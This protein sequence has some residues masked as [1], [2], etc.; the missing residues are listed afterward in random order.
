MKQSGVATAYLCRLTRKL[1]KSLRDFYLFFLN[2]A[3]NNLCVK[4]KFIILTR[5]VQ[6]DIVH[7]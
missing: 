3:E 7:R 2:I 5:F 4:H 1:A 6:L